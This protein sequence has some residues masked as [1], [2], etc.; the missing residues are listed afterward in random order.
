MQVGTLYNAMG[1]FIL[2]SLVRRA[3]KIYGIRGNHCQVKL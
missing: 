1:F 3:R 2:V